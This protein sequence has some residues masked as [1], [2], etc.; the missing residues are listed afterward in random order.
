MLNLRNSFPEQSEKEIKAIAKKYFHYLSDLSLETLKTLTIS[1]NEMKQR[2]SLTPASQELLNR[3]HAEKKSI[4][5]VLGHWGNWEWGGH[6]FSIL[7][8][9]QLYVIYHPLVNRAFNNFIVRLRCRFG[10]KLIAMKETFRDLVKLKGQVTATA[11]IAD[12]TP[13]PEGAH[14]MSFLNQDTPVFQGTEKIARKLNYPVV[15]ISI[16]RIRRGYYEMS[17]E[18]LFENPSIAK[19]G[20]ITETHTR[21]LERDIL[22]APEFWLWSHRR[23]K[24]RRSEKNR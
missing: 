22:S 21:R 14:W 8:R 4:I 10:T 19:E 23:W 15:Y 20:E 9:Q 12:Q 18:T 1:R 16:R 5:L 11:F 2:C 13:P 3:Y 6:T 17:A 24:H 7:C